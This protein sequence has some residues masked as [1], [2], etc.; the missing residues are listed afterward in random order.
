[1]E[2]MKVEPIDAEELPSQEKPLT[3]EELASYIAEIA[4]RLVAT[5]DAALHSMLALNRIMR[6]PGI[7][8]VLDSDLKEQ[9]RDLWVKIKSTGIHLDNPP[10]L[11]GLPGAKQDNGADG[12]QGA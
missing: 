3:R 10:L 11:F 1:M 2:Q 8:S 5:D 12:E 6:T 9:A 7:E 4:R